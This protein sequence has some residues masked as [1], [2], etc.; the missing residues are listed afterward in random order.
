MAVKILEEAIMERIQRAVA[1]ELKRL[2]GRQ[3]TMGNG[4]AS[5]RVPGRRVEAVAKDS[6]S[7]QRGGGHA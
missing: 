5:R 7:E 1:K 4:E 3:R 6:T 2:R